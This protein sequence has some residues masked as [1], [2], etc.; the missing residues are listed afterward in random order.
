MD[1]QPTTTEAYKTEHPTVAMTLFAESSIVS[2]LFMSLNPAE[3]FKEVEKQLVKVLADFGLPT[4]DYLLLTLPA[5]PL[6]WMVDTNTVGYK[7]FDWPLHIAEAVD[8]FIAFSQMK[9]LI[10]S[11]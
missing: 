9:E 3:V 5:E 8:A 11:H 6:D 4:D 7:R 1:Q 10:S 2:R